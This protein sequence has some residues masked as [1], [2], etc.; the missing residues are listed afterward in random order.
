MK[1]KGHR[2]K[3]KVWTIE[4]INRKTK[5]QIMAVLA[6]GLLLITVD[7]ISSSD[8]TIKIIESYGQ[9]Y[10]IRPDA[11]EEAGHLSLNAEVISDDQTYEK[12]LDIMLEPYET[13]KEKEE[14]TRSDEHMVM[15]EQ[16]RIDYALRNMTDGFNEDGSAKKI[17]LPDS[18]DSGE[19]IRWDIEKSSKSNVFAIAALMMVTSFA[20]YKNRL[21]P[22]KKMQQENRNSVMRQLPEFINRLVLLLNAGLVLNSAFERSIEERM[23]FQGAEDDYFYTK[24]KEVYTSVRTANGSM[25]KELRRFARESGSREL[26]RISNIISDNISKGVE[27]TQKLQNESELLWMNRKKSCEEKGRLAE[28]KLTLPLVIFLMALIVITV[29]PALLEL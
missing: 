21:S 22:M 19:Q 16:E 11:G 4:E 15:S 17:R 27:L 5:R 9:L 29:A 6:A 24:M 23:S 2:N 13:E 10:M 3:R 1:K 14:D 8:D 26:M 18:L 20:I 28:T 12:K 7:A 25:H